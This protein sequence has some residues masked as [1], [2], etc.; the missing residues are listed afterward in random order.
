MNQVLSSVNL[1]VL[2]QSFLDSLYSP[3]KDE[4]ETRVSFQQLDL[5]SVHL[6]FKGRAELVPSGSV[7]Q[8]YTVT[9]ILL[10]SLNW[11]RFLF[12]LQPKDP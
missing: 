9:K 12:D 1:G 2:G 5:N 10:I 3:Q 11:Y 8:S 6:L 7:K 4:N